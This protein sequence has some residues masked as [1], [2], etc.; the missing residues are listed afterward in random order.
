MG[1]FIPSRMVPV[2]VSLVAV[3]FLGAWVGQRLV[4]RL[5]VSVFRRIVMA[6]LTVAGIKLVMDGWHGLL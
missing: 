4:R 5:S 6:M 1:G 3:A 2:V